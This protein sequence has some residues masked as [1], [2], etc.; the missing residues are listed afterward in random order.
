MLQPRSAT[1]NIALCSSARSN[2]KTEAE[3]KPARLRNDQ[4]KVGKRHKI[5]L[6]GMLLAAVRHDPTIRG[7]VLLLGG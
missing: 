7:W 6:G 4:P 2:N 5:T 3:A 1:G